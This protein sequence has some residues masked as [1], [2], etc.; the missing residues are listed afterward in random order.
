VERAP[1]EAMEVQGL[2]T[3]CDWVNR[4]SFFELAAEQVEVLALSCR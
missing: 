4:S 3:S 1:V 2:K